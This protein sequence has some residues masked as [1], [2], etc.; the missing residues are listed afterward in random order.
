MF[1]P[2]LKHRHC[3]RTC[4]S[5]NVKHL[6][7]HVIEGCVTS[8]GD[9]E[10]VLIGNDV[11]ARCVRAIWIWARHCPRPGRAQSKHNQFAWA[12][13]VPMLLDKSL[14]GR[15]CQRQWQSQ[16]QRVLKIFQ[17]V[18]YHCLAAGAHREWL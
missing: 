7:Q 8:P 5:L 14:G 2:R 12:T 4:A 3:E 11:D 10:A 13:V 9:V 16:L 1:S 6:S 17:R 15:T 18:A